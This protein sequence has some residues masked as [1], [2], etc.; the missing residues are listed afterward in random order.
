MKGIQENN[1]NNDKEG[2]K[3]FLGFLGWFDLIW[4]AA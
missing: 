1:K 2:Q 3:Y 4:C